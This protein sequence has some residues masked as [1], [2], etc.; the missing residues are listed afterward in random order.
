MT[1]TLYLP[2]SRLL[3]S[4]GIVYSKGVSICAH[5]AC[6]LRLVVSVTRKV[7]PLR[8]WVAPAITVQP[9]SG[10]MPR[11]MALAW[12]TVDA[13]IWT[14]VVRRLR[15]QNITADDPQVDEVAT[16]ILVGLRSADSSLSAAGIVIDL[17]SLE[18]DASIE[19]LIPN[20]EAMQGI[21]FASMLEER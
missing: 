16:G 12:T 2:A 10:S 11:S 13:S 17:P 19:I 7:L 1:F 9:E 14:A 21:Y 15:E 6:G 5:M 8:D 20:L 4:S 3:T 18:D